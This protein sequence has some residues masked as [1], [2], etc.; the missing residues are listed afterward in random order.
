MIER[1]VYIFSNLLPD[2]AKKDLEET[3]QYAGLEEDVRWWIARKTSA[4]LVIAFILGFASRYVL[5][6]FHTLFFSILVFVIYL[7]IQYLLVYYKMEQRRK[8][9]EELL[10]AY[11]QFLAANLNSGLTPYQA[12]KASSKEEFSILYQEMDRAVSLS[13]GAKPFGEALLETT[14]RINSRAYHKFIH[15]FVD[16]MNTGGKLS[17]LLEDLSRDVMENMQL[18]QEISTRSK[19]YVLFIVF[20]VMVGAPLLSAVSVHF[21]RTIK[22][23]RSQANMEQTAVPQISGMLGALTLKPDFLK[24]ASTVNIAVT[25]TIASM[26]IAVIR[27]GKDKYMFK[28][29]VFIIPVSVGLFYLIDYVLQTIL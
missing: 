29:A 2:K 22:F 27:D 19:S 21:L 11:L 23:I 7:A 28:Y 24:T 20:A 25:A 17:E 9:V 13:L 4:A 8:T 15:L 14:K 16:G 5:S 18:K 6:T 10:P 1:F 12:V 3:I 26:L